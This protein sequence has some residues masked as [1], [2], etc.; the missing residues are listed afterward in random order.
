MTTLHEV[1]GAA[2]SV[3]TEQEALDFLDWC[4]YSMDFTD[5]TPSS[6]ETALRDLADAVELMDTKVTP[7]GVREDGT[8]AAYIVADSTW[9]RVLAIARGHKSDAAQMVLD[10]F[11][12]L[13]SDPDQTPEKMRAILDERDRRCGVAPAPPDSPL[14]ETALREALDRIAETC[15]HTIHFDLC[16]GCIARA[17]IKE[18]S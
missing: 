8:V 4:R 2:L 10:K 6:Q 5:A 15:D 17:T 14:A 9:H 7:Y 16:A 1:R 11:R 13:L 18:T 12:E 3:R